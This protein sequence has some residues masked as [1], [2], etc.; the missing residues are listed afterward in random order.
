MAVLINNTDI[1][2]V[3]GAIIEN[4][5]YD[6]IVGWP[7]VKAVDTN[8]WHEQEGVEA[9]L[10]SL[11]LDSHSFTIKF[12][13]KYSSPTQIEAFYCFLCSSPK[14]I[15]ADDAIGVVK[16]LR[17]ESMSS[18]R[19]ATQFALLNVKFACDEDPLK[20]YTRVAPVG[21]LCPAS[22]D[23][24][25]DGQKLSDYGV[26]V[27]DGTYE[28]VMKLGSVKKSLFRNPSTIHGS[29]YD[30]NPLLW[31]GA[32]WVRSQTTD[33]VHLGSFKVTLKLGMI[34]PNL[35]TFW[36]N[37]KVLLY[38]LIHE[39]TSATD[40]LLKCQRELYVKKIEKTLKCYYKS[41]SVKEF[42]IISG[43]RVWIKFDLTLEVINY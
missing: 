40:V 28:S 14:V 5:G 26:R 43:K 29:E 35:N 23:F 24:T 39:N 20:D 19:Y 18:L 32:E 6:G 3:Y 41:Q 12:G 13:L 25:L 1:A 4:G 34:A 33:E 17:I 21:G 10:S 8:N 15:Y 9:D 38:D 16:T 37:Y 11:R 27:L 42:R 7:G 22:S 31:N 30:Q 36:Q 2:S